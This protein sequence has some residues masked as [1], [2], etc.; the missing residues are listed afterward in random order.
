[1]KENMIF[2]HIII[3]LLCTENL[4]RRG[5]IRHFF[6]FVSCRVKEI[7]LSFTEREWMLSLKLKWAKSLEQNLFGA[8]GLHSWF[9]AMTLI[10]DG[11]S[12]L[13]A[14]VWWEKRS[15]QR[16]RKK[17]D[18]RLLLAESNAINRWYN[19]DCSLRIPA[20]LFLSYHL[21]YMVPCSWP[22]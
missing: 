4:Y 13:A 21:I 9:V 7:F 2:C 22:I 16:R 6:A 12:G 10:L 11:N 14:H 15:F 5:R 18:L 3:V 1:M 20:Y 19:R 8:H 17:S